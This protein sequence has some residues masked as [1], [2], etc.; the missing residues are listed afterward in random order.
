[1]DTTNEASFANANAASNAAPPRDGIYLLAAHPDWRGSRVNKRLLTAGQQVSGVLA[2]DLYSDY[3]DYAIDVP[4]EQKKLAAAK[5]L[6]LVH[7]I[8]WYSMPALQKLWVDEVLTYGWAYG[9][10]GTALHGKDL[11]LVVTTG[12]QEDAYHPSGYN[13]YFFD[14]FL[15][16]YEQTA[17]LCGMRFL[18]PLVLHGAHSTSEEEVLDHVNV[19]RQRL[20]S[21]PDWPEI[22]GLGNDLSCE[23][24]P[25]DRPDAD[26]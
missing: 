15:P 14:A 22:E 1:M 16:P 18:P 13:R 2:G 23:V 20:Q 24:P 3:P 19:F 12:G 26:Y 4:A 21:Y 7:P 17:A 6:V 9:P 11:W 25:T 8:Q 5:M 10:E